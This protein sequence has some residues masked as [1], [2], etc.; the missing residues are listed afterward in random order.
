MNQ[1]ASTRYAGRVNQEAIEVGHKAMK[2]GVTL[3]EIDKVVED[4]IL[5]H[6]CLPVFKGYKDF[7]A[8]C[9]L[10]PNDVVVHGVPNGYALK[11]GDMLTIDV[12]CS[13]DGWMVDS[14]RTFVLKESLDEFFC[15]P[16][17]YNK[18][19]KTQERLA[20][21]S[22]AVLECQLNVLKNGCSLLD[23]VMAA[24]WAAKQNFGADADPSPQLNIY[25]Q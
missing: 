21:A 20:Y 24:E 2:P 8:T 14:A 17:A 23:I 9:C 7:P 13:F 11:D 15:N 1:I 18:K 22:I 25:P 6:G 12:G 19:Y 10:S 4:Y 3:L 16:D 5:S